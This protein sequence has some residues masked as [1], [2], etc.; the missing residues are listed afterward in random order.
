MAH[1]YHMKR[2]LV[3]SRSILNKTFPADFDSFDKIAS[4]GQI[5]PPAIRNLLNICAAATQTGTVQILP[6]VYLL[7]SCSLHVGALAE[8][9][10]HETLLTCMRGREK[11]RDLLVEGPYRFIYSFQ[12]VYCPTGHEDCRRRKPTATVRGTYKDISQGNL[13]LSLFNGFLQWGGLGLCAECLEEAKGLHDEG[14]KTLWKKLPGAFGLGTWAD[15]A[16]IA[17]ARVS[18]YLSAQRETHSRSTRS[19]LCH[20]VKTAPASI[21][22]AKYLHW[23]Q[24]A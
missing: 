23:W 17:G 6:L 19:E 8:E 11:L 10:P 12:H 1:K 3:L 21:P 16:K 7:L 24:T 20:H 4:F 14:R 18:F 2:L 5:K 13:G 22:S 9:F 15:L